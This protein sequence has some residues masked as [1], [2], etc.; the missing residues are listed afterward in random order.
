MIPIVELENQKTGKSI[1]FPKDVFDS[2]VNMSLLCFP[3]DE[4]E[5]V[6]M[7]VGSM[8]ATFL[9]DEHLG[10]V[11]RAAALALYPELEMPGTVSNEPSSLGEIFDKDGDLIPPPSES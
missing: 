11:L 1:F 3:P 4:R 6:E 8:V 7:K 10:A 9:D 2:L 5:R